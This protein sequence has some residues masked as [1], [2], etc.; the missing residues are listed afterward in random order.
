MNPGVTLASPFII[1]IKDPCDKPYSVQPSSGLE[2]LII[3]YTLTAPTV[4][5]AFDEFLFNPAWCD[6]IYLWEVES[7]G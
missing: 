5:L 7:P 3:E 1:N 6:S 2:D 4:T